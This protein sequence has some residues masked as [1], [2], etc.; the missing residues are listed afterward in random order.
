MKNVGEKW[1]IHDTR[2]GAVVRQLTTISGEAEPHWH[3][4]NPRL[5]HMLTQQ[6]AT[7]KIYSVDVDQDKASEVSDMGPAVKAIWP[8]AQFTW[9]RGTGSPSADHRYWC[10]LAEKDQEG[11]RMP[12]G[13]F[14]WDAR[15]HRI[16]GHYTLNTRP[17]QLTTS[18]SGNHCLMS[19]SY[20]VSDYAF[21]RDFSAPFD[22]QTT[23][24]HLEVN[25]DKD[26]NSSAIV[27]NA[28]GEDVYVGT[29]YQSSTG[30]VFAHNLN[31]GERRTLFHAFANG[32]AT[33][34]TISGLGHRK[35]GWVLVS[36]YAEG[37][38]ATNSF[39]LRGARDAQRLWMHRRVF[40]LDLGNPTQ[41][42]SIAYMRA[43][44][45]QN[46]LAPNATVNQDF[47]KVLFN[48]SWDSERQADTDA[49]M[50][51][52]SPSAIPAT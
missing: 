52:I 16:V 13:L 17:E 1:Q 40:A 23:T 10:L 14:T 15:Q 6:G 11:R 29:S 49:Y 51:E 33:G 19:G 9:T 5:I 38:W 30:E 18:P 44:Y 2:T 32:I 43:D 12:L 25:A 45:Q 26:S 35:P 34:N 21:K 4:D 48:S 28:R 3:P 41:V 22:A 20:G 7:M 50:V 39:N 8:D 42:R 47:T 46:W 37:D 24:A 36:G 31:T 27:L